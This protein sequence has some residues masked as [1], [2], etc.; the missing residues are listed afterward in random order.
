MT[1]QPKK[2]AAKWPNVLLLPLPFCARF[3]A[4]WGGVPEGGRPTPHGSGSAHYPTR[5]GF[6]SML[7][8]LPEKSFYRLG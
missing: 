7:S 4:A 1:P 3:A 8:T 6:Y 5:A 2:S